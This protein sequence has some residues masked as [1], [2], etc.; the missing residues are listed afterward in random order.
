MDF[1]AIIKTVAPWIGTA[2]GGPLGGMAVTAAA[3]ALGLTE[4]TTDAIKAA[5]S[6]ATPEQLLALKEA[7]QNFELQMK[8]LG[9]ANIKDLE[10][11]AAADRDSARKLQ[12]ASPS[13]VPAV[14][15]II[16]TV[17]FFGVLISMMKGW[18]TTD[19]SDALLLML[20]SLG[21]AWTGVMAFW[22][23]TT[24]QSENKT[25]MLAAAPSVK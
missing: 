1:T 14:L 11:I 16:V 3:N 21:T 24:R 18:L 22:F 15:S 10:A 6:G 23:G 7:D 2:L 9:F 19:S 12:M 17:G 13:I 5:V 4:K 25:T 20:G 8:A